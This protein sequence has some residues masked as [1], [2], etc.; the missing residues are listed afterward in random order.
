MLVSIPLFFPQKEDLEET[1][2][3]GIN[4]LQKEVD[5]SGAKGGVCAYHGALLKSPF[6]VETLVTPA[7]GNDGC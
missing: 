2:L 3:D 6:R 1:F 4:L 7:S 5:L